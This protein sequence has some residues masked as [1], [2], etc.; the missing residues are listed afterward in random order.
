MSNELGS[1]QI[2]VEPFPPTGFKAQLSTDGGAWPTWS[3]DG[4]AI[5]Y[6]ALHRT[7]CSVEVTTNEHAIRGATPRR[8]MSR[9]FLRSAFGSFAISPSGDR[10]LLIVPAQHENESSSLQITLNWPALLR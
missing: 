9:P 4:R 2:Y 7:L 10:F 1:E 3:A 6:S 8:L 5:F